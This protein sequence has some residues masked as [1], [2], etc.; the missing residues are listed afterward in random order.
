MMPLTKDTLPLNTKG[1]VKTILTNHAWKRVKERYGMK[2]TDE[3]KTFLHVGLRLKN[4]LAIENGKEKH[5]YKIYCCNGVCLVVEYKKEK[6]M[7]VI[8]TIYAEKK[9]RR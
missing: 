1:V 7:L 5:T 2:K 3:I 9:G 4:I 8:I 6:K